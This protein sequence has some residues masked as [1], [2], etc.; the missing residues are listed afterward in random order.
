M[1]GY[2]LDTCAIAGLLEA[3]PDAAF[4]AW[5]EALDPSR[6]YLSAIT[7]GDLRYA[8]AVTG[9]WQRRAAAERWL[10]DVVLPE[11]GSRV[12]AFDARSADCWARFRRSESAAA[13]APV[14]VMVAA[15]A[16]AYDLTLVTRYKRDVS[17]LGVVLFDPWQA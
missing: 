7:L 12:L 3:R 16:A 2:L 11:L 6:A 8:I 14:E 9:D 4:R 1:N 5:V 10:A 17:D 15:T 13:L